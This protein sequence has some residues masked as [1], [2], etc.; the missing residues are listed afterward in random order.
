MSQLKRFTLF[1]CPVC[2]YHRVKESPTFWVVPRTV[3]EEKSSN[4]D[5]Q[6]FPHFPVAAMGQDV[7]ENLPLWDTEGKK[8]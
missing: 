2:H 3:I 6:E 7:K 4:E 1:I 5:N 8:N